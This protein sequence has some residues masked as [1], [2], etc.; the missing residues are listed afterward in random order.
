MS[1]KVSA[2]FSGHAL[3]SQLFPV[4]KCGCFSDWVEMT[5]EIIMGLLNLELA[6]KH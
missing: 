6:G 5:K 1:M 3:R 4:L 2:Q